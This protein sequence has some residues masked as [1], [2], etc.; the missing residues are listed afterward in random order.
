[1]GQLWSSVIP[2][3][4]PRRPARS[5]T[6]PEYGAGVQQG[7]RCRSAAAE[8][9]AAPGT[10]SPPWRGAKQARVHSNRV[11]VQQKTGVF[12]T[13]PAVP[14][15]PLQNLKGLSEHEADQLKRHS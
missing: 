13:A 1:M 4:N 14:G 2:L 6:A 12:R 5:G 9:P 8:S 15:V 10:R 7:F 11:N 3:Q